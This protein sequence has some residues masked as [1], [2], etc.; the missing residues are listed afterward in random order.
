MALAG[1][2][3]T[4]PAPVALGPNSLRQSAA[5]LTGRDRGAFVSLK[6]KGTLTVDL[7]ANTGAGYRWKL[8]QPVDPAVLEVVPGSS[9]PL[10][11]VALA[12]NQVTR[13]H[14]DRWI[15]KAVGPGTAKVRMIYERPD[16]RLSEA[17]I[18][19]FTVNAE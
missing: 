9:A 11:P 16:Q 1:C 19:E 5:T 2:T 18:F 14:P 6:P 15:F 10:P 4:G 3:A 17:V 12:P 13:P 7:E 8:A